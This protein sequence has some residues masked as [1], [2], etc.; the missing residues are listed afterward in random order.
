MTPITVNPTPSQ[1]AQHDRAVTN[2]T[3]IM[4]PVVA[5]PNALTETPL[6]EKI[7]GLD[8]EPI[9]FKLIAEHDW[10]LELAD[11]VEKQYKQY[12]FLTETAETEDGIPPTK[13]IDEFWHQHIL[14]TKKYAE[15]CERIFGRFIHHFPYFGLRGMEDFKSFTK[16]G[17]NAKRLFKD[18][19]DESPYGNLAGCEKG[20]CKTG[21]KT[22]QS[23]AA[24][25]EKGICK[26]GCKTNKS[27]T[28]AERPGRDDIL[29]FLERGHLIGWDKSTTEA[30]SCITNPTQCN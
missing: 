8:L 7:N 2:H 20:I 24:G 13:L 25:C 1:V 6:W 10:K 3:A 15:D 18:V 30:V 22:N 28:E 4:H 11:K 29:A 26:T 16:A 19:F 5:E 12:L 21:C 14:D 17:E 27:T 9:K 23:V